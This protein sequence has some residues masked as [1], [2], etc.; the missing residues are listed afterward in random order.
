MTDALRK[1]LRKHLD[2]QRKQIETAWWE[3]KAPTE[4]DRLSTLKAEV[5][6]GDLFDGSMEDLTEALGMNDGQ[7][8]IDQS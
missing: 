1:L 5:L 8:E 4:A 7:S 3:G 2:D 6:W